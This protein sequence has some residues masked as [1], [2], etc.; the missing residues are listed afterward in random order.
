MDE[1]GN[2]EGSL[3]DPS[4]ETLKEITSAQEHKGF[5]YFGTL[6]NDRIGRLD[7]AKVKWADTNPE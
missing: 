4:G 2:I 1:D 5:L 3:H 6:H 7:L